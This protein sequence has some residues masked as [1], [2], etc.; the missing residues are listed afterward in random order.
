MTAIVPLGIIVLR[1][2]CPIYEISHPLASVGFYRRM[3]ELTLLK[4]KKIGRMNRYES[5]RLGQ[6][7]DNLGRE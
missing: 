3:F 1:P 6:M 4:G 7:D 2:P 5:D